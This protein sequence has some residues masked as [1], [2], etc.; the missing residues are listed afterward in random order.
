MKRIVLFRFHGNYDVCKNKIDL[1]HRFNGNIPIYGLFGGEDIEQAK[2][3]L[4]GYLE[5]VFKPT[6]PVQS[7]VH[8]QQAMDTWQR[9]MKKPI[10]NGVWYWL[11]SDLAARQWYK[12]IGHAIDFD[13]AHIVEWDLLLLDSLEKLYSH[14]SALALSGL[15]PLK[16]VEA[17]WYWTSHEPWKAQWHTL[18]RWAKE[19]GYKAEPYSCLGPGAALPREFLDRYANMR[20]PELCHDELRLPLFGQLF[21]TLIVDTGFM[22]RTEPHDEKYFNCMGDP[23]TAQALAEGEQNGRKVFHPYRVIYED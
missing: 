18:L 9:D 22:Q 16:V 5:H 3:S 2:N 21:N 7:W 12:E 13:V 19:Q 10:D 1:L 15:I 11:H 20:I 14:S 17:E 23:I 6:I 8:T 4:D